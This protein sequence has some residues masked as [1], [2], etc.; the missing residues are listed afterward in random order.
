MATCADLISEAA[1]QLHGWGQTQD[2]V[3]SLAA[4][5]LISEV[6]QFTVNAA[7]GQAVGISAGTVE[8]DSE[9][10]Y[11][12]NVDQTTGICTLDPGFGRGDRGTTVVGHNVGAKVIS[13]PKFP[14][15]AI[16]K[17][18][19]E[20]IGGVFPDLFQVKTFTTN[21]TYPLYRYTLPALPVPAWVIAVEWQDPIGNWLP[22]HSFSL[23]PYDQTV[24]LG[25][26]PMIGRP[27]RVLYAGEPGLLINETDDFVATTGL[28]L[29]S[30]DVI[31]LAT[32]ARLTPGLDI[33]RAQLTSVEQSDRG[34]IVPP[35]AGINVGKYIQQMYLMRLANE[36]K[37]L[38]RVYR[39]RI[40]KVL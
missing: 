22:A 18:I 34:R 20:S 30:Y 12:T 9:L 31:T 14:R 25:S 16:L 40:R 10:L 28:P 33:S 8:I 29:S 1:S 15:S 19:N 5:I 7:S 39:P 27:L 3:A 37:A 11:V 21:V 23:D 6:N 32:V 17:Q 24:L 35:N 26:G 36:A 4:P 2:R 38:R 13:R